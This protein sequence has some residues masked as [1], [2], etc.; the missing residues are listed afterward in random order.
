MASFA[1]LPLLVTQAGRSRSVGVRTRCRGRPGATSARRR[2][3]RP[4]ALDG[5]A[6]AGSWSSAPRGRTGRGERG[7]VRLGVNQHLGDLGERVPQSVDDVLVLGRH[8]LLT[9][10]GEDRGDQG[11]RGL[12]VGPSRAGR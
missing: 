7:Q 12:G 6:A 5:V 4:K 11:A 2:V 8:G 10:L 9:G 3:S 1:V